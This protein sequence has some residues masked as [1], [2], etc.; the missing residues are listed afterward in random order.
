LGAK[1]NCRCSNAPAVFFE[2]FELLFGF[3][4]LDLS[5]EIAYLCAL[6]DENFNINNNDY[7]K[8]SNSH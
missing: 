5:S 3:I 7:E 6:N 4:H 1:K 2:I 8:N